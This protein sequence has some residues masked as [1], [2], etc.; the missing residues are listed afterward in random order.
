MCSL[1]S[2]D[3]LYLDYN[4][5]EISIGLRSIPNDATIKTLEALGATFHFIDIWLKL[6][7]ENYDA[8]FEAYINTIKRDVHANTSN[9]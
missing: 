6:L 5:G 9:C 7:R 4:D 2:H 8:R 1:V 3:R